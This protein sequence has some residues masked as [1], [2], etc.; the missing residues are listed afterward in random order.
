MDKDILTT[1]TLSADEY[2]RSQ[3]LLLNTSI[4]LEKANKEIR[5]GK[6][7]RTQGKVFNLTKNT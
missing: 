2:S 5:G 6:E 3:E 7:R 4:L 1:I